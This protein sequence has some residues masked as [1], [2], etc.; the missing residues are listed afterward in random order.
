MVWMAAI[1]E[2]NVDA[3]KLYLNLFLYCY[4]MVLQYIKT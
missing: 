1:L 3:L 4:I 2:T